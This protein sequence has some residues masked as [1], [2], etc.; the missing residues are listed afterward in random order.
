M[1][2]ME[3]LINDFIEW[4]ER[5]RLRSASTIRR[6]RSVLAQLIDM[7]IDP[8]TADIEEIEDWWKTRYGM[9]AATRQNELACLRS[10]YGWMTRHDHRPDDPTRRL[11][12]PKVDNELPRPIG[13][14]DLMRAMKACDEAGKPEIRRAIAL[15]AYGGLRVAEAASIDWADIDLDARMMYVRGKGRKERLAGLSP[16]L[17]DEI[18]PSMP[19]GNIVR[20][21]GEAW[22][23]DTL[24]R[25]VNRFFK[26]LGIDATFHKL[27]SRYVTQ[28]I[29]ETGDIYAVAR[30]AG[31]ASIET[32]QAYAA[33]SDDA[34]HRIAAAAAR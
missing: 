20:S 33:L 27:R 24:Q 25:H 5:D 23:P 28:G 13:R 31:W 34:L 16:M 10:F 12:A 32:A 7:N 19:Q 15:G 22:R 14:S 11:D 29:A 9:S 4:A 1:R 2:G 8:A 17:L 6:Y 26:S 30:A 3:Q 18:L 21:G